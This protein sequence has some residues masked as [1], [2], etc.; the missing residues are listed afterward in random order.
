MKPWQV[1]Q[2]VLCE[3]TRVTRWRVVSWPTAGGTIRRA[4]GGGA[5]RVLHITLR[6]IITPR[7]TGEVVSGFARP[8]S[9]AGWVSSPARSSPELTEYVAVSSV[10]SLPSPPRMTPSA[11]RAVSSTIERHAVALNAG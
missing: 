8:A 9:T 4:F 11:K 6:R 2:V 1:A 5:G 10:L 3:V 7:R